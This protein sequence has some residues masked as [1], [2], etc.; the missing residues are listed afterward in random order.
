MLLNLLSNAVKF[1]SEGTILVKAKLKKERRAGNAAGA[2]NGDE[3]MLEVT[4]KDYG[5]G[6]EQEDIQNA[7]KPFYRSSNPSILHRNS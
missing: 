3:A 6:M 2:L 7:F 4:V 1:Q 5:V